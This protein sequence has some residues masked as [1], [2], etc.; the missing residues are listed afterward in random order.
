MAEL[1]LTFCSLAEFTAG[2]DRRVIEHDL[3]LG[4]LYNVLF[5]LAH[6][7]PQE[8]AIVPA[9]IKQLHVTERGHRVRF[10]TLN[11]DLKPT[12][13]MHHT[14]RD[15]FMDTRISTTW[16]SGQV[17]VSAYFKDYNEGLPGLSELYKELQLSVTI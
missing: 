7:G 9:Q 17:V 15:G 5:A 16:V 12:A 4:S 1:D 6:D 11:E 2:E 3:A 13:W 10:A 14:F 8:A